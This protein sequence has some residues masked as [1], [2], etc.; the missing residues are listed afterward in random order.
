MI[1][2]WSV[3]IDQASTLTRMKA[4][5]VAAATARAARASL[6][7]TFTPTGRATALP[8]LGH[9]PGQGG[10]RGLG[11]VVGEEGGVA[12]V[13]HQ[14][15]VEAGR[16]EGPGVGDGGGEH[17]IEV[18]GEAGRA[19]ERPQ[20]D[21]ADEGADHTYARATRRAVAATSP[22]ATSS[23]SRPLG[24]RR[25]TSRHQSP[26]WPRITWSESSGPKTHRA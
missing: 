25:T 18:T 21:H 14:Q 10:H 22:V 8:H 24:R 5:P 11:D 7:R 2:P 15:R 20:V 23:F 4:A 9:R 17:R 12:E 1:G 26:A 13:L 16:L 3:C 6:R 19:G